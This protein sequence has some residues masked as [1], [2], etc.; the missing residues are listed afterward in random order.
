[1]ECLFS[2]VPINFTPD[3]VSQFFLEMSNI[4]SDQA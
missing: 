3:H 1:M 2:Q 4:F